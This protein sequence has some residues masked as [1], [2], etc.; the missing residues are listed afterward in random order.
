MNTGA[1]PVSWLE[2]EGTYTMNLPFRESGS[3][4]PREERAL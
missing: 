4:T 2:T 1:S 3:L